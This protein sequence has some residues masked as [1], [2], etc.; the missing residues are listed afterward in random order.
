MVGVLGEGVKLLIYIV[1]TGWQNIYI[2]RFDL[3][4]ADAHALWLTRDSV[5]VESVGAR[6]GQRLWTPGRDRQ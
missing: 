4:R 6:R 2:D 1:I 3:W 5:R